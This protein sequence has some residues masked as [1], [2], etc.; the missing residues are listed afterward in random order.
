MDILQRTIDYFANFNPADK[1]SVILLAVLMCVLT[2]YCIRAIYTTSIEEIFINTKEKFLTDV[3]KL[4]VMLVVFIS[5]NI[6]LTTDWF[7]ALIELVVCVIW[8]ILYLVYCR[9]EKQI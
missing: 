8:Y 9:K 7:C 5:V 6:I 2:N 4:L 1:R 3:F